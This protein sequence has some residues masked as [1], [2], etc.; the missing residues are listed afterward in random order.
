[1]EERCLCATT[2]GRLLC[3][4]WSGNLLAAV[5]LDAAVQCLSAENAA[6]VIFAGCRDGSVRAWKLCP[7]REDKDYSDRQHVGLGFTS[8][9]VWRDAHVAG[10]IFAISPIL[11]EGRLAGLTSA[12]GD[13]TL[14]LWKF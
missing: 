11:S 5:L 12:G 7:H 13:G 8:L 1:M 2:D 6:R 4:D 14:V 3:L 9:W 10:S